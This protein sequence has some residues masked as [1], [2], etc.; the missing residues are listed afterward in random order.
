[1]NQYTT[2]SQ[3]RLQFMKQ[4]HEYSKNGVL[5]NIQ[6][7][8]YASQNKSQNAL[9]QEVANKLEGDLGNMRKTLSDYKEQLKS[10]DAKIKELSQ[11]KTDLEKNLTEADK[12]FI[13]WQHALSKNK[14]DIRNMKTFFDN[15]I[16]S[17]VNKV[18]AA[19]EELHVSKNTNQQLALEN[20]SLIERIAKLTSDNESMRES[21]ENAR[22]S[23]LA[24]SK[25]L[26]ENAMYKNALKK[27]LK[28]DASANFSLINEITGQ[29]N[30][31]IEYNF[32]N[33]KT[34]EIK[35]IEEKNKNL[36]KTL[37]NVQN[38]H[39]KL[40]KDNETMKKLIQS[41]KESN[42]K[43]E[44]SIATLRID[45]NKSQQAYEYLKKSNTTEKSHSKIEI[46]NLKEKSKEMANLLKELKTSHQ[47]KLNEA[48][49]NYNTM[50]E[51]FEKQ[52][53][54][55]Q[56][57]NNS[58]LEKTARYIN[59]INLLKSSLE[60]SIQNITDLTTK[61]HKLKQQLK[62]ALK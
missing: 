39:D 2:N 12:D 7:L 32:E 59:E 50:K 8:E 55:L 46:E 54:S 13:K 41:E 26:K 3:E 20:S 15:E 1:M 58:I 16:R 62:Q 40:K 21:V 36:E 28:S 11:A 44:K 61:N 47:D 14:F 42:E 22:T 53:I 5:N 4:H 31:K 9:L 19:Q 52:F 43:L 25:L 6:Q 33:Q 38:N 48:T 27:Q 60:G 30:K 23:E 17:S 18:K 29:I 45:L 49:K 10:K 37:E 24:T 34:E 57:E 56:K 51:R 35:I